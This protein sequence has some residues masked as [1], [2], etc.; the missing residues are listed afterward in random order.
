MTNPMRWITPLEEMILDEGLERG[1]KE[2]AA[3]VLERLLTRRFGP[4]S[5][6]NQR[7]LAKASVD[8]LTAW[9]DAVLDATSLTQVFKTQ[10]AAGSSSSGR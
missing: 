9:S 10:S 6:T 3:A 2:G 4:L 1:R 5:K 7:K 8:Q